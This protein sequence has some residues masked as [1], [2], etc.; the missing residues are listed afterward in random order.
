MKYP[1]P[2][3]A[4]KGASDG[5]PREFFGAPNVDSREARRIYLR[6]YQAGARWCARNR[7]GLRPRVLRSIGGFHYWLEPRDG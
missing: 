5:R 2:K 3:L 4:A 7:P 1:W 6:I